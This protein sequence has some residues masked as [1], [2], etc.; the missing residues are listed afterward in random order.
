MN[1]NDSII[2]EESV[3]L[4]K[5]GGKHFVLQPFTIVPF[6]QHDRMN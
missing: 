4:N 5:S 2:V 3:I 6:T 1:I